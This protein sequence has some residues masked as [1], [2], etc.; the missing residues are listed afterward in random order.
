MSEL[1]AKF[2]DKCVGLDIEVDPQTATIF[3]MVAIKQSTGEKI[4]NRNRNIQEFLNKLENLLGQS[5]YLIGHNLLKFDLEH[6]IARQ[7]DF[8]KYLNRSIDTL[9]L[10]PLAFPLKTY[11]RLEKPYLDSNLKDG[12]KQD[13]EQD[14]LLAIKLLENQKVALIKQDE[15]LLMAYHYLSTRGE[16]SDGFNA[17][18][19]SL[20]HAK[21]PNKEAGLKAIRQNLYGKACQTDLEEKILKFST[22]KFSW[23]L[24]YAL[25]WITV[26]ERKFSL[27]PWVFHEFPE[28][29]D[30]LRSLRAISCESADCVWCLDPHISSKF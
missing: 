18:F 8:S 2:I 7:S 11:H 23:S 5:D 27:P 25:S 16:N 21:R 14:T 15:S 30:V 3:A 4:D 17:F 19:D 26:A 24:A 6:I 22:P 9:W 12:Q 20:R 29:V 13:P 10:S 28:V 1:H